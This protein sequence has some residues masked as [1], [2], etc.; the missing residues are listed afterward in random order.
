M[1]SK[2]EGKASDKAKIEMVKEIAKYLEENYPKSK[3]KN[4]KAILDKIMIFNNEK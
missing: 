4:Q 3:L 2:T 1:S